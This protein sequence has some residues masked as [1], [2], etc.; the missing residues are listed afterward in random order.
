[1]QNKN[2]L[3][4]HL[5]AARWAA[6][7]SNPKAMLDLLSHFRNRVVPELGGQGCVAGYVA[8]GQEINP[9][10]VLQIFSGCGWSLCLPVVRDENAPMMF[11]AYRSGDR[12]QANE[13]HQFPEPLADQTI[14]VPDVVIVPLLGFDRAGNRIGYG[15]GYYDRTLAHLRAQGDVTAIGLAYNEQ[16]LEKI[17]AE[18]H[19]QPLNIIVTPGEV[20]Y[21]PVR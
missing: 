18:P 14:V 6:A 21:C 7:Q 13:W 4:A 17:D 19:D 20:I 10:P 1:M 15:K 11:R 5:R 12:L 8:M 16:E 2:E 3:R 9:Q